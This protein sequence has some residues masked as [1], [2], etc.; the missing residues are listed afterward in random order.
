LFS[1]EKECVE[2][3]ISYFDASSKAFDYQSKTQGR[4]PAR[5]A[6]LTRKGSASCDILQRDLEASIASLLG[7]CAYVRTRVMGRVFYNARAMQ[8][9]P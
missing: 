7:A 4:S 8:D 3:L 6:N 9:M 2:L 1:A 5:V